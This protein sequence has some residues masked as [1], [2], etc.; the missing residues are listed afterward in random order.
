MKQRASDLEREVKALRKKIEEIEQLARGQ[1]L[2]GVLS[3]RSNGHALQATRTAT[4]A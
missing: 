1:G 2:S 3:F 4:P